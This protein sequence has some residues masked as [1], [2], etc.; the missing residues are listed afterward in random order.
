MVDSRPEPL[1]AGGGERKQGL[2]AWCIQVE[3]RTGQSTAGSHRNGCP[4]G[5]RSCM[6]GRQQM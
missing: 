1:F 2:A 5:D 3:K 6:R 4:S